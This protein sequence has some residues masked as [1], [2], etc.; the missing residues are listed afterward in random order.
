MR[1]FA[2]NSSLV[3]ALPRCSAICENS[4]FSAKFFPLCFLRFLLFRFFGCGLPRCSAIS[5][6]SSFLAKF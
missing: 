2:A 5:E 1:S 4:A 6:N 3:A